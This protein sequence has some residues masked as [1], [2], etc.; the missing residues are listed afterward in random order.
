V[1]WGNLRRRRPFSAYYGWDR[2]QPVDRLYIERFLDRMRDR[3]AGD[4][5]E[6]RSRDYTDRFG[7][8]GLRS[9]VVDIDPSNQ[10]ATVVG[11]LCQ[12]ATLPPDAYDCVILTQTLQFLQTP[13]AAIGNLW[14]SLRAGGT[15]LITVPCAA[16]VDHELADSDLWR[17]TPVGLRR[18]VERYCD[19]PVV[20]VEAGGNLVATLASTLGLAV[21]DL[22][23]EDL[24]ED[25][26]VFPIVACVALTKPTSPPS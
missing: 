18:F 2:G 20:H 23:D 26:P 15:L 8:A 19:G 4:V 21:E 17:W 14:R 6:V 7:S 9:H 12:S 22:R 13:D 1:H 10:A 5:L 16:R 3:I 24:A 11:D 25:D